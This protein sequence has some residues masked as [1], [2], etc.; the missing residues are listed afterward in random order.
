VGID[1]SV[2]EIKWQG[3]CGPPSRDPLAVDPIRCS[4]LLRTAFGTPPISARFS[5]AEDGEVGLR[6]TCGRG[7]VP[8][9]AAVDAE[10][11]RGSAGERRTTGSLEAW[12][13]GR[14]A[15]EDGGFGPPPA[16]WRRLRA[17]RDSVTGDAGRMP[18]SGGLS[19]R[20]PVLE[21]GARPAAFLEVGRWGSCEGFPG[22]GWA[23][24]LSGS[25]RRSL[26]GLKGLGA[27][28][29]GRLEDQSSFLSFMR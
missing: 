15:E 23:P 1:S 19:A 27:S 18:P 11:G 2:D 5:P 14:R 3:A 9:G 13:V 4:T 21:R 8:L 20:W 26:L 28:G 6:T 24:R 17:R 16:P 10:Y 12:R 7:L 25:R 22:A 29:A